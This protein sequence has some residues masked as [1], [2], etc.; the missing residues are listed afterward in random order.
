MGIRTNHM[1]QKSI[2]AEL[3]IWVLQQKIR[4]IKQ[5]DADMQREQF[6]TLWAIVKGNTH[7]ESYILREFQ[8]L[9]CTEEYITI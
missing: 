8:T 7:L 4:K 9:N 1:K 2:F 5:L 3:K 6:T